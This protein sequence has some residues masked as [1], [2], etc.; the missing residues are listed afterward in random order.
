MK[1]GIDKSRKALRN[2]REVSVTTLPHV[3]PNLLI[4]GV[5]AMRMQ[6]L[7]AVLKAMTPAF[8][9]A[10][11]VPAFADATIPTADIEGA[12]D[13]AIAQRYEGSF[14]VS[15]EAFAYTD[16]TV[17]LSPLLRNPAGERDRSNNIIYRP[18]R[19]VD[20]EGALTRLV[21]LL[22]ENRSP[23][24][25][26]RNYQDVMEAAGGEIIFQCRREECGGDPGRISSGGGD[27]MSLTQFFF[28]ESDLKDAPFSTGKC[29]LTERMND[30]RFFSARIPQGDLDAWVT[31]Q[32]YSLVT[33]SSG[34]NAIN[35]RTV[36]IVHVLEPEPRDRKMVLVEAADMASALD[37]TGSISLYGI[38]FDFDKADLKPESEPTLREIASLLQGQ[39]QLAVL[40]VGHTDNQGSYNYN[41]DLSARRAASVKAALVSRFAIDAGRLTTAGA[42]MMAPI[43]SNDTEEGRARNRRVVLVKAN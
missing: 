32:T 11:G 41:L 31:V 4:N 19:K 21:Y 6:V 7:R 17:P 30:Q 42:G 25:V 34:C 9:L 15:Y 24:E 27:Q 16:F 43:A 13:N 28:Y 8:V 33:S 40:V 3:P 37:V 12:A 38:Y 1:K 22:P 29:A 26:L 18:E 10:L 5:P 35:G 23:L 2:P 39:P 20:L 14:I 36:A